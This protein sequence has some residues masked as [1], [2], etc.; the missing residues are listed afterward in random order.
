M[1]DSIGFP[2]FSYQVQIVQTVYQA[3]VVKLQNW[4]DASA[5]VSQQ[6]MLA[7]NAF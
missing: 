1:M 6:R 3:W 7:C 5:A 4:V 2:F